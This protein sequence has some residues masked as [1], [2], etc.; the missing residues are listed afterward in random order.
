[1]ALRYIQSNLEPDQ[2]KE[3]IKALTGELI[4]NANEGRSIACLVFRK[5]I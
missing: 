4:Y 2:H 3:P 1:M 5:G